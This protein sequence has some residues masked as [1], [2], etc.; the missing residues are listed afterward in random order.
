MVKRLPFLRV[1]DRQFYFGDKEAVEMKE[2]GS[3]GRD[4][5]CAYKMCGG[6]DIRKHKGNT[7]YAARF[8]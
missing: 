4:T 1:E 8:G 7:T 6:G 2:T 5:H 3:G